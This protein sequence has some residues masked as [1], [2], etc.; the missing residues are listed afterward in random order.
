MSECQSTVLM[1][2]RALRKLKDVSRAID[3]S[4]SYSSNW[5]IQMQTPMIANGTMFTFHKHNL[6][7]ALCVC[8]CVSH[9][10]TLHSLSLSL[11]LSNSPLDLTLHLFV[12]VTDGA[13]LGVVA[14]GQHADEHL[15][16]GSQLQ[17][18]V[19]GWY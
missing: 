14:L 18:S 16:V 12:A 5:H 19:Q 2:M 7:F 9:T 3:F 8:A 15:L 6:S 4:R 10:H 17:V 13:D 1:V 11:S